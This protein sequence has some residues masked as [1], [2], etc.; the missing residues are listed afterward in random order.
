[1]MKV[2]RMAAHTRPFAGMSVRDTAHAMGTPKT[3]QS[4]ATASPITTELTRAS[5]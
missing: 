4:A 2:P 3:V 1:M 5:R